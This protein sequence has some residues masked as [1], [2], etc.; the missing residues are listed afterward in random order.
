MFYEKRCASGQG[1]LWGDSTEQKGMCRK[2]AQRVTMPG[3]TARLKLDDRAAVAR[4][5][6]SEG[7]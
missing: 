2:L 3:E 1:A 5:M 4:R 6:G 7:S